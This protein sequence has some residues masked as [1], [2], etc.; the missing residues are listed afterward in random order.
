MPDF[1]VQPV[2]R[3]LTLIADGELTEAKFHQYRRFVEECQE[4]HPN[5]W[6]SWTDKET[7]RLREMHYHGASIS[8]ISQDLGRSPVAVKFMLRPRSPK[9]RVA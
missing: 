5:A 9:R 7:Q 2:H 8:E 1:E 4:D 3:I 6:K